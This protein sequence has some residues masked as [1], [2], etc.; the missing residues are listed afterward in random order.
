MLRGRVAPGL[1][2]STRY[3][4]VLLLG[5]PICGWAVLWYGFT[6]GILLAD[7]RRDL[8]LHP[9]KEGWL[10]ASFFLGQLLFVIPFTNWF[11]RY[12][13]VR[14]W[15]TV[16][17]LITILLLA[18]AAIPNYWAQLG[19]RFAIAA[20]FVAINPVRT[21][22]IGIWFRSEEVAH[23]NGMFNAGFGLVQAAAFWASAS[24]LDLL[25][26][27]RAMMALF[28]GLSAAATVLWT[29][30]ARDVAAPE[31]AL[32]SSE[33][34]STHSSLRV[35]WRREVWILS[36]VG[37]GGGM[38]WA[39]FLTFWPALAEDS[40]GL[41][42]GNI[43]LVFGFSALAIVPG[44]LA[45]SWILGWAGGR[46]RLLV[47]ATMFQVPA[48]AL[49]LTT[50][51]PLLLT[52]LAIAQ[53]LSWFYFPILLTVPFDMKGLDERDVAVATAV[54]IT[55]NSGALA[56]GPILAGV[57][58]EGMSLRTVL[59]LASLGPLLSTVGAMLL[60]DAAGRPPVGE[61]PTAQAAEVR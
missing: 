30:V 13:P 45:A 60:G 26:G 32:G 57:L 4:W 21:L 43:S 3:R 10:S 22:L 7:M 8:D 47:V 42:K 58:A 41:S 61:P 35:L 46:R 48:Y 53:G 38:T 27:W 28:A 44:S 16:L 19:L 1:L 15:S 11:A 56:L 37:A 29:L 59:A 40:L 49:L 17:A 25:G 20:L 51:N 2:Q 52:L 39:T 50:G 6:I 34:A 33:P 14:T 31:T 12:P 24:L 23:A 18:A 54:F 5:L 36:L 55:V 9:A